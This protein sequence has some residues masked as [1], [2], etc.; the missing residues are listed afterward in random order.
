VK[1]RVESEEFQEHILIVIVVPVI[2]SSCSSG[3]SSDSATSSPA[4]SSN[5][6]LGL[7][8]YDDHSPTS[9]LTRGGRVTPPATTIPRFR[10][11]TVEDFQFLKVLGKGSF[12]KVSP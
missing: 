3:S 5:P 10:K 4:L 6:A 8:P 7:D 11:Y 12:G 1:W 2:G 9:T